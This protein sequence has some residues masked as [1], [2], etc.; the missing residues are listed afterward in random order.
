M[1]SLSKALTSS[2]GK[3]FA[4]SLTGLGLVGF[5]ITHLLGNAIL[6]TKNPELFNNYSKKLHETLGPLL[7]VAEVALLAGL[8]LHVVCAIAMKRQNMA[9]RPVGYA[10]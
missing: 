5:L 8:I 3:K 1:I 6:Y 2:V 7:Y 4:M 9:A 10:Q